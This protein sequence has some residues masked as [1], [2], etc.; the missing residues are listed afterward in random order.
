MV[1][2]EISYMPVLG[3]PLIAWLGIATLISLIITAAIPA[4][5][6]AGIKTVPHKWHS[7][8]AKLTIALAIIHGSL[9]I[10]AYI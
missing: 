4:M 9:G 6:R 10:L 1:L 2:K 3:I 8:I 5:N 7:R